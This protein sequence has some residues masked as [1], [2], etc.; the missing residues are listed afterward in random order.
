MRSGLFQGV[1]CPAPQFFPRAIMPSTPLFTAS[2]ILPRT[3]SPDFGAKRKPSPAPPPSPTKKTEALCLYE[4]RSISDLPVSSADH[5]ESGPDCATD[6]E[7]EKEEGGEP[8]P[9]KTTLK[10]T[11]AGRRTVTVALC[12]VRGGFAG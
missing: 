2:A 6:L 7:W 12:R 4:F 9:G 8:F 3:C 5:F 1:L 11:A 10:R